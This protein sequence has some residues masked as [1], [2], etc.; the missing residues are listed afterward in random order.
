MNK[1]IEFF[2]PLGN[3]TMNRHSFNNFNYVASRCETALGRT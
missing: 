1:Y 2:S 3:R